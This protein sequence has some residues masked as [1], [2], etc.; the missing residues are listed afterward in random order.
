M[1]RIVMLVDLDSFFASAEE[2]ENPKLKGKPVVVGG[3]IA[4]EIPHLLFSHTMA[5]ILMI[6]E[7][8][9]TI[10]ELADALEKK[11]QLKNETQKIPPI[12]KKT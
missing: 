7:A 9:I 6:G 11:K 3:N 2:R 10:C 12:Q 4:N 5:D 8:E 1:K